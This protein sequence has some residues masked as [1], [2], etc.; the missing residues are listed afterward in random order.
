MFTEE[1]FSKPSTARQGILR[2]S[3]YSSSGG[4]AT[5]RRTSKLK[6]TR[7]PSPDRTRR[8]RSKTPRSP[9]AKLIRHI[10]KGFKQLA[11][12]E[13]KNKYVRNLAEFGDA[14]WPF[15]LALLTAVL[16]NPEIFKK[17]DN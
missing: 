14:T 10:K 12:R 17:S 13:Y 7:S 11:G 9:R 2:A 15:F 6:T 3:K 8:R 5:V 1:H 16:Y 4:P